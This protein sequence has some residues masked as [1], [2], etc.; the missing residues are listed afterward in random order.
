MTL[1]EKTTMELWIP[2][3]SRWNYHPITIPF[4]PKKTLLNQTN[5]RECFFTYPNLHHTAI[6]RT[7]AD[8]K[9]SLVS[10]SNQATRSHA[11]SWESLE[12][13]QRLFL[14]LSFPWEKSHGNR[15]SYSVAQQT[16]PSVC[17]SRLA[18]KFVRV[19]Q[20]IRIR[21]NRKAKFC[22]YRKRRFPNRHRHRLLR[23]SYRTCERRKCG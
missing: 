5:S 23:I 14:R 22:F 4:L 10:I 21:V 1:W 18:L 8:F 17:G 13:T 11:S 2:T 16:E 12:T 6:C 3:W 15:F 19:K 20:E 7:L 9:K